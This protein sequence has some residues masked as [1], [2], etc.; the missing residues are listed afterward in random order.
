MNESDFA[1]Q[2]LDYLGNKIYNNGTRIL[3]YKGSP[4]YEI[5][6]LTSRIEIGMELGSEKHAGY[7]V[8]PYSEFQKLGYI[9]SIGTEWLWRER[10]QCYYKITKREKD[11][12]GITEKVF[13]RKLQ[14]QHDPP[15]RRLRLIG[16]DVL[17]T[18]GM[19]IN[20]GVGPW[21]V[22]DEDR[23]K[24][25]MTQAK[26]EKALTKESVMASVDRWMY[27][28][29]TQEVKYA[30]IKEIPVLLSDEKYIVC[31]RKDIVTKRFIV[32]GQTRTGKSTFVNALAHRIFYIWEDRVAWLIDPMNQFDEISMPQAYNKF[33]DVNSLIGN[34]PK[35]IPAVQIYLACKNKIEMRHKDISLLLT[36]DFIEF[37]KKYKYYTFGIKDMDV[38]DTIR[39]L[40][41]FINEIKDVSSAK[42]I[43]DIMFEKIPNA[44]KDKGM[45]AMIYKWVNT[46]ETVFKEKFTSNMY[47]GKN[48][49]SELTVEFR[50]GSS[51]KG[52][53]FIM[54][55]EAGLIPILNISAAKRQRWVRNYLADLMQ[56]IVAHQSTVEDEKKHRVWIIADELNEIYEIGKK[57]D[58][59]YFTFEE[60]YR[61]GGFNNI[62][63]IG[64]TQSLD[65]LNPEMYKNAEYICCCYLQDTKERKRVGDTFNV[66]K[67]TYDKIEELKTQEMMI[68]SKE[69]LVIYDR[70]GKRRVAENRKWFKG[71]ILPPIN[72]HKVP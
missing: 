44:H 65:K 22:Y 2:W 12:V 51:M 55:Y 11:N 60:L 52:H 17:P 32:V 23:P 63:F 5:S 31:V 16:E 58:N 6:R 8:M 53:P 30:E 21:I 62:G 20:S 3:E 64:N 37:L 70:W 47:D 66:D 71:K 49:C 41:D 24:E 38:G 50:D 54:C 18:T 10:Q 35:P 42:E 40:E 1:L 39:Y 27:G 59:A 28:R 13:D 25:Y 57:K 69:P 45:Q 19:P 56:K 72:F 4:N 68:F 9:V 48:V 7:S 46:F 61:Q 36:L 15:N 34:L 26:R 67:E 14:I 43:R 33:N 29:N